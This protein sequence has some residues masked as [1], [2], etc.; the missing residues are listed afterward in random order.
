MTTVSPFFAS[1]STV[2]MRELRS[3]IRFSLGVDVGLPTDTA[4]FRDLDALVFAEGDLRIERGGNGQGDV[5]LFRGVHIDNRRRADGL[6][7]LLG[8]GLLI[9]LRKISLTASS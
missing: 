2:S 7:A 4:F 9:D 1:R 8:D 3:A 5:A 6:Q